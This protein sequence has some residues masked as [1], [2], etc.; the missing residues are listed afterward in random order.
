MRSPERLRLERLRN[1]LPYSIAR[2]LEIAA[3]GVVAGIFLVVPVAMIGC[4][5]V[6]DWTVPEVRESSVTIHYA[7]TDR[8]AVFELPVSTKDLLI[9]EL[10]VDPPTTRQSFPSAARRLHL[11]TDSPRVTLR[12]RYRQFRTFDRAGRPNAWLTPK[13]LFPGAAAIQ[14]H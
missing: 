11:D 6:P 5:T 10:E 14:E 9:H 13:Q 2:R 1:V 12:C 8:N 3:T 7:A 4:S